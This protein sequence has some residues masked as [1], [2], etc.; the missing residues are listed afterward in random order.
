MKRRD[1]LGTAALGALAGWLPGRA[2]KP[3]AGGCRGA[4][5][6][7]DPLEM[8]PPRPAGVRAEAARR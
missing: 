1:W 6:E 3:P 7:A 2:P 5:R 8:G 4:A